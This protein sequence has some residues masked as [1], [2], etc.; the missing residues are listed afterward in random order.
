MEGNEFY[1]LVDWDNT[2]A[3]PPKSANDTKCY[4]TKGACIDRSIFL[5]R[6]CHIEHEDNCF[7]G[8]ACDNQRITKKQAKNITVFDDLNK[9]IGITSNEQQIHEDENVNEHVG[10]AANRKNLNKA[11]HDHRHEMMLH[12]M[13]FDKQTCLD[14]MKHVGIIR[15]INNSCSPNVYVDKWEAHGYLREGMLAK[16]SIQLGE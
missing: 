15:Y 10:V 3:K 1:A 5:R 13:T 12:M 8:A 14:S 16:C 2:S 11:L 9:G 4:C 7:I 6:N